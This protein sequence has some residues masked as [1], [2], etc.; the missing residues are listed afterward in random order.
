MRYAEARALFLLLSQP[1]AIPEKAN[2]LDVGPAARI[3]AGKQSEERAREAE[4]L[5]APLPGEESRRRP[6]PTSR[7]ASCDYPVGLAHSAYYL[8]PPPPQPVRG[9]VFVPPVIVPPKL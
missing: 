2:C 6:G 5:L 3:L 4:R 1:G 9:P 7:S 8:E